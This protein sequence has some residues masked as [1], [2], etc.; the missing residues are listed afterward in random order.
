VPDVAVDD[1]IATTQS[2]ESRNGR[3]I[4]A[5]VRRAVYERDAVRCTFVDERGQRCQET[6][7]LE[8]HHRQPFSMGGTHTTANLTLHCRAHN[9]LAA[10]LDFGRARMAERQE[11]G[12]HASLASERRGAGE[13]D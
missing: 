10:E 1:R 5:A 7:Y 2:D 6:R 8:I 11:R 12:R 13:A 4:P 3:Y 9:A